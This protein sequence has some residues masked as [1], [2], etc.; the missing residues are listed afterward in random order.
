MTEPWWI[1]LIKA[2]VIVNLVMLAFAYTTLLERKLLG[3]LQLRYGPNRAGFRGLLQPIADLVKLVRKE[4]FFPRKV[5]AI[6]YIVAPAFSAFNSGVRGY[7]FALAAA[8][9]LIGPIPMMAAVLSAIAL[10][11]WR[12]LASRSAADVEAAL[13]RA[14]TR[15]MERRSKRAR[16]HLDDKVLTAWNGLLIAAFARGARVLSGRSTAAEYLSAAQRAAAFIRTTL[17]N[18]DARQLLRRYRSGEAGISAYAED[19]RGGRQIKGP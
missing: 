16:P 3:R 11:V 12:Q 1:S 17:W 10:L 18:T 4:A 9:W 15:L 14:R 6:P 5:E 13:Q 2:A 8:A 7:N 19:V